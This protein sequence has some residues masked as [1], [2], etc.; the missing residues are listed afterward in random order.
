[1][2]PGRFRKGGGTVSWHARRRR[3]SEETGPGAFAGDR[4]AGERR[5]RHPRRPAAPAPRLRS[6]DVAERLTP[7]ATVKT[8]PP[9]R[10]VGFGKCL[11]RRRFRQN[12]AGFSNTRRSA[13]RPCTR[14]ERYFCRGAQYGQAGPRLIHG[15]LTCLHGLFRCRFGAMLPT[16]GWSRST[17]ASPP[18]SVLSADPWQPD[19]ATFSCVARGSALAVR[20]APSR[21]RWS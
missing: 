21:R 20:A 18:W 11:L 2:G 10:A 3:S 12:C 14:F 8:P 15:A 7:P 17:I 16:I 9:W 13:A 19:R 1:M 6:G 4:D 5:R